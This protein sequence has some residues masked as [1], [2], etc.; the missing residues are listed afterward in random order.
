M[1]QLQIFRKVVLNLR[2][3]YLTKLW[4]VP[5]VAK[6]ELF[7][8]PKFAKLEWAKR[9]IVIAIKNSFKV[10]SLAHWVF[11]V[12]HAECVRDLYKLNLVKLGYSDFDLG[13]SRFLL[14]P[15]LPQ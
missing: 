13:L 3:N 8:F 9:Q 12:R 15:L 11:G 5:K 2:P 6:V 1:N 14:M 7:I 10:T 4:L